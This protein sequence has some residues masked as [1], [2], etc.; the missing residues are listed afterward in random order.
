MTQ[1]L[2]LVEAQI[3]IEKSREYLVI[4]RR[5]KKLSIP[6]EVWEDEQVRKERYRGWTVCGRVRG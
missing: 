5:G 6:V 3:H 1:Q 2:L 4:E